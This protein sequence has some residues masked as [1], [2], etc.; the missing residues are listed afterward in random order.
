[1]SSL[2]FRLK[3]IDEKK[4]LEEIKHN[5]LISEKYK[6]TCKYLNYVKHLLI[7]ASIVTGCVSISVFD[8]LVCIPVGITNSAVGIKICVNTAG[9]KI[10]KSI[11]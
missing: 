9:M 1:M 6:K 2:E 4:L 11:I 5:Y 7:L 3:K 8:S 10:Y